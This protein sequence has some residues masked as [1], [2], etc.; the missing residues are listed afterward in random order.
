MTAPTDNQNAD[1]GV[2]RR[3][4]KSA[5]KSAPADLVVSD[6]LSKLDLIVSLLTRPGGASLAELTTA[7]GWQ[8]HSVRGAIAG[9]LKKKGHVIGSEKIDSIRHYRIGAA[10]ND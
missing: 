3:R 6:K 5:Q 4:P 7:T 10:K 1:S 8:I 9:S 2:A